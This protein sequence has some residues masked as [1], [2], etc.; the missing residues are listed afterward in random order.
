MFTLIVGYNSSTLRKRRKRRLRVDYFV[1]YASALLLGA[2]AIDFVR[3]AWFHRLQ[4]AFLLTG[5]FFGFFFASFWGCLRRTWFLKGLAIILPFHALIVWILISIN[6]LLNMARVVA[7]AFGGLI[8]LVYVEW[9]VAAQL[10]EVFERRDE[11]HSQT[12]QR[13]GIC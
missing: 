1:V 9:I 6:P 7:L 13:E 10:I 12:T 11:L 5:G 4:G 2:I 3:A 8:S